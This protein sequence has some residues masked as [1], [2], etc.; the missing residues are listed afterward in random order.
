MVLE[1]KLSHHAILSNKNETSGTVDSDDLE[2]DYKVVGILEVSH[3][4]VY[5]VVSQCRRS[6]FGSPFSTRKKKKD[7]SDFA[8]ASSHLSAKRKH[9]I[10]SFI[11]F[12]CFHVT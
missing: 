7:K 11:F 8:L 2:V 4:V 5:V 10:V 3:T 6:Q 9:E 12:E 1:H